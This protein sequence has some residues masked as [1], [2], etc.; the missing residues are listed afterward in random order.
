MSKEVLG[1]IPSQA[2]TFRG[3]TI[4]SNM[5]AATLFGDPKRKVGTETDTGQLWLALRGSVGMQ[6]KAMLA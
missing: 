2:T 5:V 1:S 3:H 6:G 4:Y